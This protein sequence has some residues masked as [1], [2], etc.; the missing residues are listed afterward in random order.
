MEFLGL[1]P[2]WTWP[3]FVSWEASQ[4]MGSYNLHQNW[5]RVKKSI[6][7]HTC[8]N[9]VPVHVIFSRMCYKEHWPWAQAPELP[10]H[11][12]SGKSLATME[13]IIWKPRKEMLEASVKGSG[14]QCVRCTM[15]KAEPLFSILKEGMT[16]TDPPG[17]ILQR[18][19][20]TK[21]SPCCGSPGSLSHR[22]LQACS[23][24]AAICWEEEGSKH[25]SISKLQEARVKETRKKRRGGTRQRTL[26]LWDR[27]GPLHWPTTCQNNISIKW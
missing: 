1:E 21:P 9:D 2:G 13:L 25:P 10:S 15:V 12:T 26:V 27:Q 20:V 18:C 5:G 6:H 17:P 4:G 8:H 3:L 14:L 7:G 19:S 11:V 16:Y 23:E 22:H 24:H